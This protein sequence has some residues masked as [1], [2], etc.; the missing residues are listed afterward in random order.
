GAASLEAELPLHVSL[1]GVLTID[2]VHLALAADDAGIRIA[3]A[4]SASLQLGPISASV[5]RMGLEA[6]ATF[7][8]G[9]GNLGP[10]DLGAAFLPPRGVGMV[11]DASVVKGGG[12]IL[13]D[14]AHGR[15]AGILQL[16]IGDI[17]TVTAIGLVTTR[18]PDG[19]EGFSLLVILTATFPPIQL[20]V[21]FTLSGL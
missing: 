7:P 17:V 1:L 4:A 18:M 11:I 20:G 8:A 16:K 15:Y 3:I 5:Q 2:I 21:G 10:L 6:R 9:G 12:F 19:S 14:P 13:N